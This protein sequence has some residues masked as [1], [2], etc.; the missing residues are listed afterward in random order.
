M[1]HFNKKTP[2]PKQ[3]IGNNI[4]FLQFFSYL[5]AFLFL[6]LTLTSVIYLAPLT[7]LSLFG[8]LGVYKKNKEL[9]NINFILGVSSI[10]LRLIILVY[11]LTIKV[12]VIGCLSYISL[13]GEI[14]YTCQCLALLTNLEI[15]ENRNIENIENSDLNDMI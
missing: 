10:P 5:D 11:Y 15:A 2:S 13:I 6:M 7:I 4:M 12:I 8:L 1:P 14:Y 9:L 3:P